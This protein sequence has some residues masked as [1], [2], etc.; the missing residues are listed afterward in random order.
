MVFEIGKTQ[1]HRLATKPVEC[2]RLGRL[3]PR[4][5]RF[6]QRFVFAT[7]N[8]LGRGSDWNNPKL[9]EDMFGNAAV[10]NGNYASR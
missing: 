10:N 7:F 5:M 1:F 9:D 6:D 2:F 8:G 4:P 3:Y